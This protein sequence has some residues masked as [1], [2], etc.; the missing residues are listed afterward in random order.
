MIAG[1]NGSMRSAS[2]QIA[3]YDSFIV[4]LHLSATTTATGY[5]IFDPA[6][7]APIVGW[8]DLEELFES[9]LK[10]NAKGNLIL[11]SNSRDGTLALSVYVDEEPPDEL[12][13]RAANVVRDGF[14]RF[15]S[16]RIRF[17]GA[18]D[19]GARDGTTA[20]G[21]SA[22]IPPGEYRA[23]GFDVAWEPA[24][25]EDELRKAAGPAAYRFHSLLDAT[26]GLGCMF[27]LLSMFL[28]FAAIATGF[29]MHWSLGLLC[30]LM[31]ILPVVLRRTPIERRFI[32]ARRE[33]HKR[34]P[35]VVLVLHRS[36]K[37][38]DRSN[39]SG[40]AFGVGHVKRHKAKGFEVVFPAVRAEP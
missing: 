5:V 33:V 26:A 8:G 40:L 1:I 34:F 32:A 24:R 38:D 36:F 3:C 22:S 31:L 21:S 11:Y 14:C 9:A 39:L 23:E 20:T 10:D 13:L 7:V 2:A 6:A 28:F 12:R 29:V 17:A 18:E 30:V 15:P 35:P 25:V 19:F 27:A 37:S 4:I 16:G